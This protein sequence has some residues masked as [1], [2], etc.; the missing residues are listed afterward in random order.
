MS[1][2]GERRRI[3][4]MLA[5]GQI[6]V[7]QATEL[8]KALGTDRQAPPR[9]PRPPV[10]PQVVGSG[11]ESRRGIARVLSIS[12]DAKGDAGDERAKVRV[13]VPLALTRFAMKF[14]PTEAKEQLNTQGIDLE[15]LLETLGDE[16]PEG[17]LVDIDASQ[18]GDG[19]NA[20][21][22]IEVV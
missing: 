3:L 21:I 14:L 4:D 8:L 5:A 17:R 6:D 12:I 20:R 15:E 16:L 1:D 2:T 13:N 22:V 7:D 10:P 9:S 18:M 11:G 19:T